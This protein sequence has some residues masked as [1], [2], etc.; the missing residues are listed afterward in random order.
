M[1]AGAVLMTAG[2]V[3]VTNLTPPGSGVTTLYSKAY[4]DK[5]YGDGCTIGSTTA[6]GE[7]NNEWYVGYDALK[8]LLLRYTVGAVCTAVRNPVDSQR[9]SA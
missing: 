6:K 3:R 8:D 9:G 7:V 5:R 4:W 1:T 2:T